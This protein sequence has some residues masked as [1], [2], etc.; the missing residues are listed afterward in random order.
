MLAKLI[1]SPFV[2]GLEVWEME[3][4]VEV[5]MAVDKVPKAFILENSNSWP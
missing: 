2:L 1:V 5:E 4:A 3:M